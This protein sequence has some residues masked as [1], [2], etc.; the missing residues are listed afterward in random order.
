MQQYADCHTHCGI[1]RFRVPAE[2]PPKEADDTSGWQAVCR[3]RDAGGSDWK[4]LR[5]IDSS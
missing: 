1:S 4:L 5:M 3:W 2:V